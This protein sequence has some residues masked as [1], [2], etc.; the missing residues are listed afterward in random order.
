MKNE[1][2]KLLKQSL[3]QCACLNFTTWT[4]PTH[5]TVSRPT[6]RAANRQAR[7]VPE[8]SPNLAKS[9]INME[10]LG[11]PLPL[12]RSCA[13]PPPGSMR[14]SRPMRAARSFLPETAP[15]HACDGTPA[16][17]LHEDRIHR[18]QVSEL[19]GSAS[20][21]PPQA[22]HESV[23]L[24]PELE[25]QVPQVESEGVRSILHVKLVKECHLRRP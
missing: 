4:C 22:A 3:F 18:P 12:T 21:S 1:K 10:P 19:R 17:S 8:G 16:A 14:L 9:N 7:C 23:E 13:R 5:T 11:E 25:V 20:G 15:G 24:F 6:T 2:G